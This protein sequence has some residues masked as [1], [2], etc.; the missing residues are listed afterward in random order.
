MVIWLNLSVEL[1]YDMEDFME[2]FGL[3]ANKEEE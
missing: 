3:D 2:E 1:I